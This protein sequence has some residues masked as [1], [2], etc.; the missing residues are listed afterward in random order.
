KIL[1]LLHFAGAAA[2]AA[3][4]LA[5]GFDLLPEVG[6]LRLQSR[7]L[8]AQ[9]AA[10]RGV[11]VAL[12]QGQV[13]LEPAQHVVAGPGGFELRLALG[14]EA[15]LHLIK[16]IAVALLLLGEVL[17]GFAQRLLHLLPRRYVA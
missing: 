4:G 10:D 8:A 5:A 11:A 15:A 2:A 9:A 12:L 1:E 16:E 7:R 3:E 13:F 14:G 17:A 6:D